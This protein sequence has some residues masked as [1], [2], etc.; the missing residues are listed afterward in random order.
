MTTATT[1]CLMRSNEADNP[2][3][4]EPDRVTSAVADPGFHGR[5]G[6]TLDGDGVGLTYYLA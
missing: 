4:A 1:T 6:A 3:L 2:A 5:R